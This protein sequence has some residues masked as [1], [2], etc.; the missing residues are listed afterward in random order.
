[1]IKHFRVPDSMILKSLEDLYDL[2]DIF[3]IKHKGKIILITESSKE[4]ISTITKNKN[5]LEQKDY[6][7]DD[8]YDFIST[9]SKP[10][11]KYKTFQI[12]YKVYKYG[13]LNTKL[14][15]HKYY[16]TNKLPYY[17]QEFQSI[18]EETKLKQF[19]RIRKLE[20]IIED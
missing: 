14:H 10:T 11:S 8:V 3:I 17:L 1:M 2:D 4:M 15:N 19:L 9:F 7:L 16:G 6:F 5:I 20:R 13:I 18:L 12:N